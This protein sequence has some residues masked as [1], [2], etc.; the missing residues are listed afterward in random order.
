MALGFWLGLLPAWEA[1]ISLSLASFSNGNHLYFHRLLEE[2]LTAAGHTV[3]IVSTEDLPQPRIVKYLETGQVTLYWILQTAERDE[4]Y[5]LVDHKLTR[6]LIGQRV[7]LI[8]KGDELL[9]ANVKTLSDLES[10]GKVAGLGSGWFDV[11]VWRA[12]GLPLVEQS[13]DWR[14]LFTMVARHDRGVDYIPRGVNEIVAE[15]KE[16]P[17][18]AIEPNLLLTYPRDLVFYL[19]TSNADL[20][21]LIEAALKQAEKSGLQKRLIDEYFGPSMNSLNLDKRIRIH[22]KIPAPP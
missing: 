14:H 7:L 5:V 17:Q 18:L 11:S 9:Y 6:G 19:S 8:P 21:P 16:K 10:L 3:H 20:K 13:G 22:L 12:N 15:A 4:K 1:D 2:S